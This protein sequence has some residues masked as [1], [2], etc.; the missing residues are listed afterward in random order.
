MSETS[1][2]Q[3]FFFFFLSDLS[4]GLRNGGGF[5]SAFFLDSKRNPKRWHLVLSYP[6]TMES[7]NTTQALAFNLPNLLKIDKHL[8]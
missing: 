7:P 2:H 8:L 6:L 5:R 3:K 1:S 4:K